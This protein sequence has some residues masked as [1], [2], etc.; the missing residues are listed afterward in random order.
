MP[1]KKSASNKK[2]TTKSTTK[3]TTTARKKSTA[4]KQTKPKSLRLA[5]ETEPFIC[6]RA[7]DQTLYWIIIAVLA[8]AFTLWV[9]KLQSDISDLY[10]QIESFQQSDILV[11]THR[12]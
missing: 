10:A 2:T 8:I 4:S 12:R 9:V 1:A 6:M 5:A 7:N 3:K 11:P